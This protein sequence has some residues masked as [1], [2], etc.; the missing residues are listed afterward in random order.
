METIS[1]TNNRKSTIESIPSYCYK[2]KRLDVTTEQIAKVIL[3]P[4]SKPLSGGIIHSIPHNPV[5]KEEV[6]TSRLSIVYDCSSKVSEDV[7]SFNDCLET[8]PALQPKLFN[9][10]VRNQFNKFVVTGDMQETI[11][12]IKLKEEDK[13]VQRIWRNVKFYIVV[14]GGMPSLY[15]PGTTMWKMW[16]E[17]HIKNLENY[18]DIY[19]LT[20]YMFQKDTYVAEIK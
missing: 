13:N 8:G 4:V 5:I 3:E 11:L 19:P 20:T 16:N 6:E 18:Q 9:I 10:P 15:I 2:K 12:Q 1:P 17:K 14:F 7:P